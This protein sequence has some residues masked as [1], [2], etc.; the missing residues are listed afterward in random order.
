MGGQKAP[1]LADFRW[2]TC[3]PEHFICIVSLP[4]PCTW[5]S[6][7]PDWKLLRTHMITDQPGNFSY[8]EV[9]DRKDKNPGRNDL[10]NDTAYQGGFWGQV[11]HSWQLQGQYM[12]LALKDG[13]GTILT[14]MAA[15][16]QKFEAALLLEQREVEARKEERGHVTRWKTKQGILRVKEATPLV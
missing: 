4:E 9:L 11:Y 6:L 16:L 13:T 15:T 2:M 5:L 7:R 12:A 14:T 10:V 8:D 1:L 3:N